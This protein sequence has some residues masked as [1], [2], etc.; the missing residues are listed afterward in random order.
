MSQRA[1]FRRQEKKIRRIFFIIFIIILLILGRREN[2]K[3]NKNGKRA[4][5]GCS[6]YAHIRITIIEPKVSVRNPSELFSKLYHNDNN[7]HSRRP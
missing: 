1:F 7:Y 5:G 4:R 3:N 2:N 6:A